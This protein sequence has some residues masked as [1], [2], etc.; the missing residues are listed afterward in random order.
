[1][2][3]SGEAGGLLYYVTP[4]VPGGSLRD[5][6]ERESQ[7][8]ISTRCWPAIRRLPDATRA[9]AKAPADRYPTVCTFTEAL[10]APETGATSPSPRSI[11]VLPFVSVGVEPD[12]AYLG[13]GLSEEILAALMTVDGLHV[14]SRTSAFAL[15]MRS[16]SG[17]R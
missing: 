5:R 3:D 10:T 6:L 16:R 4:Y 2:H 13:E 9:L 8:P 1:M 14:A 12:D 7:L 15:R 11:A 17:G